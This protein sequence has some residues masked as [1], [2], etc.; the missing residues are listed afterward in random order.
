MLR[1]T[2]ELDP[3]SEVAASARL[4]LGEGASVGGWRKLQIDAYAGM[5]FD[6]NVTLDSGDVAGLSRNRQDGSGVW[7][8]SISGEVYRGERSSISLGTRYD[9]RRHIDLHSYDTD[10][11]L[12]F[13]S[14]RI[15]SHE[16]LTW[17]LDG[18]FSQGFLDDGRFQNRAV[19]FDVGTFNDQL[20]LLAC[21]GGQVTDCTFQ[22]G[23]RFRERQHA[24]AVHVILHCGAGVPELTGVERQVAFVLIELF[25]E[26]FEINAIAFDRFGNFCGQA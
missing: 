2:I 11:L 13:F 20:H 14:A 26:L 25:F 3:D 22:T 23:T 1:E 5:E 21:R 17:R 8:T 24:N 6:S 4:L 10:D 12:A 15:A 18:L 7:G 16:R 9:A 19:E